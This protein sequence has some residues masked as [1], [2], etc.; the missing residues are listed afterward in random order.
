MIG[1]VP[2]AGRGFK[3][4]VNYLLRGERGT[5]DDPNRVAWTDVRNLAIDDPELVPSLMRA[6]ATRNRRCKSP[7]YHFVISWRQDE[8]PTDALMR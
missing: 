1:K 8:R 2:I 3:G 5:K 4:L 7:V 6:T